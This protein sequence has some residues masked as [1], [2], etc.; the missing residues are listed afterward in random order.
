MVVASSIAIVITTVLGLPLAGSRSDPSSKR[1]RVKVRLVA[2]PISVNSKAL[3]LGDD[4]AQK[5]GEVLRFG[6]GC[7]TLPSIIEIEE[8]CNQDPS[9]VTTWCFT[10]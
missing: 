6:R 2:V 4:D 10:I 1:C 3:K 5:S 9:L 8:F 7:A